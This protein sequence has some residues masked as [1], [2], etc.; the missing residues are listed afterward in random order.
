[1]RF[2]G[3]LLGLVIGATVGTSLGGFAAVLGGALLG[4]IGGAA[5]FGLL[6]AEPQSQR[7][8]PRRQASVDA[9]FDH[10]YRSLHHVHLRLEEIEKRLGV[11]ALPP[12][13]ETP[14]APERAREALVEAARAAGTPAVKPLPGAVEHA[15]APERAAAAPASARDAGEVGDRGAARARGSA[16]W[17]WLVGGNTLVRLGVVILFFGVAFLAKYAA[18][19]FRFPIALRLAGIAAGAF[20]M[21]AIGGRLRARR[22]GYALAMQG[23]GV[24][25]LYLTVFAAL[26]LYGLLPPGRRSRC[27]SAWWSPRRGSRSGRTR[28]RSRCSRWQ[29]ASSRRCSRPRAAAAT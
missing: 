15:A 20:V 11:G 3:G 14:A 26:R 29:A 19:N 18:E 8:V 9:R 4:A 16:A 7:A 6:R 27:S 5:L 28:C 13:P 24:G 21:L 22:P 17:R 23:G 25:V 10:I 12:F 1:M 2:L